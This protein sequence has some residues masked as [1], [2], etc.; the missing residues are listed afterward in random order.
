MI[1]ILL[2]CV[3]PG[4]NNTLNLATIGFGATHNLNRLSNSDKLLKQFKLP[5]FKEVTTATDLL[6]EAIQVLVPFVNNAL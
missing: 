3:L 5:P 4:S 6:S 1:E 2:I